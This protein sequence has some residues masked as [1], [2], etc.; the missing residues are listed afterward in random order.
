VSASLNGSAL[1]E[2]SDFEV[3]ERS[4]TLN[5]PPAGAAAR[6]GGRTSRGREGPQP[7]G[8]GEGGA[9]APVELPVVRATAGEPGVRLAWGRD[10]AEDSG[11]A[12]GWETEA[13]ARSTAWRE[14]E[15]ARAALCRR[16]RAD[17]RDGHRAREQHVAGGAVQ[18][19]RQLLH[20]GEPGGGLAAGPRRRR[21][22]V[23]AQGLGGLL[24]GSR[25]RGRTGASSLTACAADAACCLAPGLL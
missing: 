6:M 5:S 19:Q 9:L 1:E 15:R 17:D 14:V 21:T 22:L 23:S 3:T 12:E 25:L 2:G 8:E 7:C 20:A 24:P 16:V 4:L 10:G 11:R 18:E 13:G